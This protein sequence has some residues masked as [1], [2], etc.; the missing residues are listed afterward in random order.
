MDKLIRLHR[1]SQI[2]TPSSITSPLPP[3]PGYLKDGEDLHALMQAFTL[4]PSS[5]HHI[6][7]R[8]LKK[9]F[10]PAMRRILAAGGHPAIVA[11]QSISEDL[12]LLSLDKG[13]VGIYDLRAAIGRHGKERNLQWNLLPGKEDIVRLAGGKAVAE[14]G[15]VGAE[16][17][18]LRDVEEKK[19]KKWQ[20]PRFILSFKD[21]QEARRFVRAWHRRPFPLTTGPQ[22]PGDEGPPIVNAELLW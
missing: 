20:P 4:I 2:H 22:N 15:E 14:D 6:S 3:P 19:G 5:Q 18:A 8:M 10:R 21:N 1:I 12:V 9:P 7:I 13:H 17:E 11:R 16:L